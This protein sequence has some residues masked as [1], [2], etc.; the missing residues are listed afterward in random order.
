MK[1]LPL[2]V[3]C[4]PGPGLWTLTAVL[5]LLL[6]PAC[7][8]ATPQAG[9][10]TLTPTAVTPAATVTVPAPASTPAAGE[11]AA[12]SQ[13]TAVPTAAAAATLTAGQPG[14]LIAVSMDSRVGVLL[15]D[16][17]AAMRD[18]VAD[19]LLTAGDAFW[20][21][22]AQHQVRLTRNR[23]NFRG[24]I[25][26][27]K[28]QLPLPPPELWQIELDSAGPVRET[29]DGHDL[30]LQNYTFHS[31]LLADETSPGQSEPALAAPG[32][33]WQEPFI[34]PA[35]PD[36]LLQHTGNAC[37]NEGGY[38]AH[39]YDSEN[40]F[41]LYDYTCTAD[42]GGPAGCH[43]T[44]LPNLSCQEALAAYVGTVQ[45]A[46]RFERL[47][48][49]DSLADQVRLGPVTNATA[50][51]LMVVAA[52]LSN[53]RLVYR[54][55]QPD[56]CALQEGAVG[57]PGWR[58]L[59][60]FDATVY[61]VGGAPLTVGPVRAEDPVHHVFEYS[62]C[63]DHFHYSFYGDFSLEVD[64][65]ASGSK[66]AFCVQSTSRYSNYELAPLTH[67]Y[68]CSV[69][70]L[71]V[72]W[73]DEYDAGLDA[74]WIDITDLTIEG[75]A[76]TGD[77]VFASNSDQFLCEGTPELDENGQPVW[78]PSGFTTADGESIDRPACDFIPGWQENNEGRL[79]V[80]IP[81]AGSFVT[82]PC[83]GPQVGP[84]RNCGFSP[85][86]EGKTAV[87]TPGQPVDLTATT[88]PETLQVVR[89]CE[90]S[91][92]LGGVACAYEDALANVT[93]LAEE[94]A[95]SFTCP[96]MRDDP[97]AAGGYS[98]YTAPAWPNDAP[99]PVTIEGLAA[100]ATATPTGADGLQTWTSDTWNV[101]LDYPEAWTAVSSGDRVT[102]TAP[103]GVVLQ[104]APVDPG[105]ATPEEYLVAAPLPNVRCTTAVN[106]H[107]L[108]VRTCSDTV[109]R[110]RT[111]EVLLPPD[112]AAPR[113]LALSMSLPGDEAAFT[114]VV[115]SM[116]LR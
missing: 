63:H 49:D 95:V 56:D 89:V 83:P 52:D 7:G 46:V 53:N 51:D 88:D 82:A 97:E 106:P 71:Q 55:I 104:L 6:L 100:P 113:L 8:A 45:T 64:S 16:F 47:P 59:L 12:P 15:D 54:Y 73:V 81:A 77:L 20:Q 19:A 72:G 80:S 42:S 23:L 35:D 29:I 75:D 14:A 114:A 32:G 5:L 3:T 74:Q 25:T 87:C 61:N 107:D 96:A 18:R 1:R 116:R 94:T 58:R 62:A 109:A 38:P 26:P 24:Y 31:T 28:G 69:Q 76:Q 13:P 66:K 78:E 68:S 79:A 4:R 41:D 44:S 21:A 36:L 84:R 60:Q 101:A 112:A 57:A 115:D 11:T 99:A 93:V 91:A 17:P 85:L 37:V 111:A 27:G 90:R 70:G 67:E 108:T 40:I 30:I 10:P 43:R 39:S 22:K 103:E 110:Q 48:W 50:P 86:P 2:L 34:F 98:V 9:T 92:V 65:T 105:G 102:F 33:V